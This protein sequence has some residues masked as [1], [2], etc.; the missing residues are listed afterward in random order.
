MKK[1][2]LLAAF[3]SSFAF[4]QNKEEH[5]SGFNV[6]SVNY[7]ID[8]TWSVYAELQERAIEDFNTP[9]YYEIKG[10]VGYNFNKNL[11]EGLGIQALRIYFNVQNLKTWDHVNGFTPEL[12]GSA[13]EFG[14]NTSGYPTPRITSFGINVTF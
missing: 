13:T 7:K 4:S 6:V 10:G 9:D 12:G 1:I 3:V 11:I 8:K 5:V 2:F 14:V